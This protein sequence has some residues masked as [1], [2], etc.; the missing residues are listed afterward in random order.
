LKQNSSL[1]CNVDSQKDKI[2]IE[3]ERERD[4][5]RKVEMKRVDTDKKHSNKKLY[6]TKQKN[7]Y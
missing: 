4:F 6:K 2:E 7:I 5:R 1:S 3:R